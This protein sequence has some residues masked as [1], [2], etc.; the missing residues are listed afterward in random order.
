ME[1]KNK[2]QQENKLVRNLY[3]VIQRQLFS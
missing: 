3:K 2:T 1:N